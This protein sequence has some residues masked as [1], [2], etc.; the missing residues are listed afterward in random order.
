MSMVRPLRQG[1]R[2]GRDLLRC[3]G[4]EVTQMRHRCCGAQHSSQQ[5]MWKDAPL[6]QRSAYETTG[7]HPLLGEPHPSD[8]RT[9]RL[10]TLQNS[11]VAVKMGTW[12]FRSNAHSCAFGRRAAISSAAAN[13]M[14][15]SSRPW[16]TRTGAVMAERS[17]MTSFV[18]SGSKKLR[19][20]SCGNER[21]LRMVR[22]RSSSIS[23]SE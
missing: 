2:I 20:V 1:D 11:V 4:L 19:R 3:M 12:P 16:A 17:G 13:A 18:G 5:T 9:K 21:R 7:V 8:C 6:R 22:S 14:R 23:G 15:R 10:T